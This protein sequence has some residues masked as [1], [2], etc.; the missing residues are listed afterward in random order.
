M[1]QKIIK[2]VEDFEI[3]ISKI[4]N[5]N[6]ID[7]IIHGSTV[8]GGFVEGKGDI[9]FLVFTKSKIS[10]Q[11]RE[12]IFDYHRSIRKEHIL[13]SQLEGCYYSV[14]EKNKKITGG[15]YLGTS[16]RGWKKIDGIVHD[17]I[18][19]AHIMSSYYSTQKSG[20]LDDV[21]NFTWK[22]VECGLKEQSE[23]SFTVLEKF[24]DYSLKLYLVYVAAR[25][26]YTIENKDFISKGQALKWIMKKDKYTKYSDLINECAKFRNPLTE[27][28]IK[29]INKENF[30]NIKEFLTEV[31]NDI[32]NS[33]IM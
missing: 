3:N 6:I 1:E 13:A 4:L 11:Q 32:Q 26:L 30:K 15:I 24:D 28:E 25:S 7:V 23:N 21:F 31:D 19:I 10:K 18:I 16:E 2:V 20:I 22:Q 5:D 9:D 27:E 8:D 29:G 12:I 17:K 14:D 33:K